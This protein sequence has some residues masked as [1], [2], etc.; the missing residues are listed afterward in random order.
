MDTLVRLW[1]HTV[2]AL[3]IAGALAF[4]GAAAAT[5]VPVPWIESAGIALTIAAILIAPPVAFI[6]LELRHASRT[7]SGTA[8]THAQSR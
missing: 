7:R 6:A 1:W 5:Y 8:R 2:L 3:I 4:V